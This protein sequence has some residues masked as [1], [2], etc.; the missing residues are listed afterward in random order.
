[1]IEIKSKEKTI[2]DLLDNKKYDLDFYQR[3]YVWKDKEVSELIKDLTDEFQRNYDETHNRTEVDKYSHYFL[4]SIVVRKES[5]KRYIIDG[6]QRLTTLTLLLIFFYHSLEDEN[7][8]GQVLPL[9]FSMHYG[10]KSFNLDIIERKSVMETLFSKKSLDSFKADK[11][12]SIQNIVRCYKQIQKH[13]AFSE[14]MLPYF[15]DWL[16]QKVDLVEI[17]AVTEDHAYTVFETMNERGVSLTETEMLR[18]NLLSN[19][20]DSVRRNSAKRVW[21]EWIQKL[22][23]LGSNEES[24]AIKAWL[25][26]QF[27]N[28]VRD[29]EGIGAKFHRWVRDEENKDKLGLTT[30]D[31]FANFIEQDFEFYSSWYFRL[32]DAANSLKSGLECVF[33]NAQNN[34]T[35]QYTLLLSPLRVGDNDEEALRKLHIV[36]TYLDIFINRRIWN[37]DSIARNHM[38][39]YI[40]RE[41]QVTNEYKL[42]SIIPLIRGKSSEKLKEILYKRINTETKP[43]GNK[44]L[45]L[46]GQNRRKIHLILARM[47]DYIETKSKKPSHYHE[48]IRRK[49]NNSYEIEHIWANKY[50]MH[51]D[52]FSHQSEFEAYRDRIGGLLLL[53]KN[54]NISYGNSSYKEKREHYLQENLLAQSLLET[55]Y[56][57]KSGFSGFKQFK[58]LSQLPFRPH[59]DFKKEDL[60]KRQK[61]YQLI[62]KNIWNPERLR[63]SYGQEPEPVTVENESDNSVIVNPVGERGTWTVDKISNL[64]PPERRE[65]YNKTHSSHNIHECY[66]MIAELQNLIQEKRWNL[67]LKFRNYYCAFYFGSRCVFGI[68]LYSSPRYAV[69]ITEAEAERES[70]RNRCKFAN[71]STPLGHAVYPRNTTVDSLRPIFE[72]AYKKHQ[73]IDVVSQ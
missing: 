5:T 62:A 22:K 53:P 30:S 40:W 48:Y 17:T 6:Q 39:N 23:E 9:I 37:G 73:N 61:L 56:E 51:R 33:Y 47:T 66:S 2:K 44:M 63:L 11:S 20:T 27:A 29:Y 67:D 14:D 8:K 18:G 31:A 65:F 41:Q 3:E 24:E 46:H 49:G 13:P 32:R 60:D 36:L 28:T 58:D 59:P 10:E 69:W 45:H 35:L 52:E 64:V 34:F 15:V 4:G 12:E 26:S 38:D 21:D 55:A 50:E 42:S 57:N 70:L 72:F 43:F 1:M 54:N 7:Q 16:L 68:N 25:R 71:Y 19:I